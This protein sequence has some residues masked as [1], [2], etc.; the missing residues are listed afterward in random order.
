[1]HW[2]QVRSNSLMFLLSLLAIIPM[3]GFIS[4]ATEGVAAKTGDTIGGLL[5]ATLGNLTELVIVFA[6]IKQ[7]LVELVKASLAGVIVTNSLFLLGMCF[8][9]GGIKTKV[10][11]FN[12]INAL[13]Q[14]SLL[15]IVCIALLVPTIVS[16][17]T[18]PSRS[19]SMGSISLGISII[20]LVVYIL[21]LIFSLKT[22][23][24]FF[25]SAELE[26][27]GL[28]EH[29]SMPVSATIL[30]ISAICIVLVSEIF[31]EAVGEAATCVGMSQAF[32]GFIIIPL[33][34]TAAEMMTVFSAAAKNILD[35]S[36][37][38]TMGSSTQVSMFI[39]PLL[40]I[41]SYYIAPVPMDLEFRGGLIFMIL[42]A[43]LS[44][45]MVVSS[46]KTAWY[47]GI[48]LLAVYAIFG[49]TLFFL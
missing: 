37:A 4:H 10:Q 29:W 49:L 41:L 42:F 43:T 39:T 13:I 20:L 12:R 5:N 25:K 19:M 44:V 18:D 11:Q 22:H 14:T 35:I 46:G 2:S 47:L 1:M 45:F 30:A 8:I 34:G 40:V 23:K 38:V 17:T 48:P 16:K 28:E 26:D 7:G 24:D 3:G 9:I 6:V 33:V 31:V 21:S 32:V 27:D 15:F 36:M